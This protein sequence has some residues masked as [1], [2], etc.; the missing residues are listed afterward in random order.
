[1]CKQCEAKIKGLAMKK[2]RSI[3]GL[4]GDGVLSTAKNIGAGFVGYYGADMLTENIDFMKEN[5]VTDGLVK[6]GGAL[7]ASMIPAVAASDMGMSALVGFGVHG[8]KKLI[9]SF[10]K[11]GETYVNGGGWDNYD[12]PNQT[13]ANKRR[14]A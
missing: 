8:L 10:A 11:E 9:N 1:M 13:A 5:D 6:V 7:A 2:R 12:R 14:L 3:K 4:T